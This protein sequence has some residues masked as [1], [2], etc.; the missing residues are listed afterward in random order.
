MLYFSKHIKWELTINMKKH[1]RHFV[2]VLLWMARRGLAL[3]KGVW[4]NM[5]LWR[6]KIQQNPDAIPTKCRQHPDEIPNPRKSP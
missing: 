2:V 6:R 5:I 4:M 1:G 3:V